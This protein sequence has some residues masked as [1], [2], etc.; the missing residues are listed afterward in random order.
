MVS[1]QVKEKS[2]FGIVV[3]LVGLCAETSFVGISSAY[4]YLDM[5]YS[6]VILFYQ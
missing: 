4:P 6:D 5:I 1:R 2:I 3:I